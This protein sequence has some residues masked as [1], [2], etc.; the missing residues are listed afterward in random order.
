MSNLASML[1][2]ITAL[3]RTAVF[4]ARPLRGALFPQ[5]PKR[6]RGVRSINACRSAKPLPHG[7]GSG[8]TTRAFPCIPSFLLMALCMACAIP[9]CD[10]TDHRPDG[11]VE[12]ELWTLALRPRFT[13]YMEQVVAEYEAAH[14]NVKV[15][16]VDVPFNAM[17]RK[18]VVAAA[19][20]RAPD[21]INLPGTFGQYAALGALADL[22]PHLP[23]DPEA[24]YLPEAVA[25]LR[26]GTAQ[27]ALPWY[28]TTGIVLINTELL[29]KGGLTPETVGSDWQT[30]MQQ[31][32]PFHEATGQHLFSLPLG[33]GS[34][35]PSLL[36][37]EGL[38]PFREDEEGRLRADLTRP[39]VLAYVTAW[40]DLYRQG[41][42]PRAAATRNHSHLVE[43][44]QQGRVALV[45]TGANMLRRVQ[46]AG[47]DVYAVTKVAEP[48]RGALGYSAIALM[49]VAV[50]S[51]SEHPEQATELAWA[52]TNASNQLALARESGVMPSALDALQAPEY[53]QGVTAA[54]PDAYAQAVTARSLQRARS[55]NPRL[56][57]WPEM[58]RSFEE[59]IQGALLDGRDVEEVLEALNERWNRMLL[60]QR[61]ATMADIPT[62]R[63]YAS[64]SAKPST[65]GAR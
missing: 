1:N 31:A 4:F 28:L 57:S 14:P 26:L 38:A 42:V 7:Q 6:Q 49:V 55:F 45:Q 61:P 30:L 24:T 53:Q 62:P 40:V 41:A 19:A 22:T 60:A 32:G 59:A 12:L 36:L 11:V 18:L 48:V 20:G 27:I 47:P 2:T 37:E 64:N 13:E 23:S 25:G 65:G 39:E 29:A 15:A 17:D 63:P 51:S 3:P 9:G 56:E 33:A 34:L 46:D 16:W 10:R 54:D 5:S 35:L 58:R 44:Y 50:T 8:K 43:L 52:L 21:V